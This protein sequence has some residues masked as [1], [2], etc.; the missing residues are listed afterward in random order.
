MRD[1]A[2]TAK[3]H[4]V[5][6]NRLYD[7]GVTER[8]AALED[9]LH[10]DG[11]EVKTFDAS[12]LLEP[13]AVTTKT[14]GVYQVFTPFWRTARRAVGDFTLHQ[15]PKRLAAR[16]TGLSPNPSPPGSCT[17]P[18]P[19]GPKVSI[20]GRPARPAPANGC[21]TSL[22]DK[23]GDYPKRRDQPE[24]E[25]TSR[26]SP[27]LHW[28]EIGPRQV[29][30]A[31]EAAGHRHHRDSAGGEVPD[32]TRLAR[33]QPPDPGRT[34]RRADPELQGRLRRFP[35]AQGQAR[36]HRLEQGPDRL[37]DGGRRACASFGPPA[38]WRTGCG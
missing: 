20:S 35:L 8:D 27:H 32:R 9:A 2:K 34:P 37:S 23:L 21:T 7:P 31:I 10:G 33:I 18:S 11:I 24:T 15:A 14:G 29:L 30:R 28:G 25:G 16:I 17:R 19:T 13:G 4:A 12:L 26:L 1:V 38:T 36:L 3:A 5:F 6:W 22:D